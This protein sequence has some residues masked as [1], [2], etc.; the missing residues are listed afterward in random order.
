ME[1]VSM[2]EAIPGFAFALLILAGGLILAFRANR[3]SAPR[4]K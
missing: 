1:K 3:K 4:S 2:I